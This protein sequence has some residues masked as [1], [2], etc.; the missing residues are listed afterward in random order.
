[1]QLVTAAGHPAGPKRL[2]FYNPPVV[3]R[4]LGL[5]RSSTLEGQRIAEHFL[6]GGV[7]T[8]VF[9]RSRLQVEIL[10]SYLQESLATRLG[11]H[12]AIRGYRGGDRPPPRGAI[13]R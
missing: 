6:R 8:I 9:G 13:A 7:Q 11:D 5:R 3:N 12:R 10:L 4:E 2:L 1:M